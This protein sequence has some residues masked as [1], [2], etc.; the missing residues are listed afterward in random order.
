MNHMYKDE[1]RLYNIA[2]KKL[3]Q[4]IYYDPKPFAKICLAK[5]EEQT[6]NNPQNQEL[7]NIKRIFSK[8]EHN[9]TL[10]SDQLGVIENWLNQID[11]YALP[12]SISPFKSK[13]DMEQHKKIEKTEVSNSFPSEKYY[14]YGLNYYSKIP[15]PLLLLDVLWIMKVGV[16]LEEEISDNCYGARIHHILRDFKEK[17][18]SGHLMKRYADQYSA[19]R[20]QALTCA[21]EAVEKNE[22]VDILTLDF[23]QFY[24]HIEGDFAEIKEYLKL[25]NSLWMSDEEYGTALE[26]T[27]IIEKIH[28]KYYDI[29]KPYTD[30]THK[31]IKEKGIS[32]LLPIELYSS[33]ILANWH[34]KEFDRK[35]LESLHPR[36]Y[37]RYADDCIVVLAK[38]WYNSNEASSV[39]DNSLKHEIFRKCF[40]DTGIFVLASEEKGYQL[41]LDGHQIKENEDEKLEY[42]LYDER[43]E[44]PRITVQN[45]KVMLYHIDPKNSTA[46]LRLFQKKIQDNASVFQYLP[47]ESITDSQDTG[48]HQLVFDDGSTYKLRNLKKLMVDNSNFS[49]VLSKQLAHISLCKKP[50]PNICEFTKN[51]FRD[52]RVNGYLAY[53]KTWEK[54]FCLLLFSNT[55]EQVKE[56]CS[57][58]NEIRNQISCLT[59]SKDLCSDLSK[60]EKHLIEILAE[61]ILQ[62][63]DE[64]LLL[65]IATPL[66]LF[67][68][69]ERGNLCHRFSLAYEKNSRKNLAHKKISDNLKDLLL[70]YSEKLRSANLFPHYY[71]IYP[72]LNYLK[73][74]DGDLLEVDVFN[75][76]LLEKPELDDSK[77][78]LSPRFIHLYEFQ[79]Y[80]ALQC[81]K[82]TYSLKIPSPN[83][84]D[85]RQDPETLCY[86]ELANTWF[87][88]ITFKGWKEGIASDVIVESL[89]LPG[90]ETEQSVSP[91]KITIRNDPLGTKENGKIRIGLA[92]LRVQ[93]SWIERCYE[94]LRLPPDVSLSRWLEISK[95]LNAA[96]HDKCDLVVFPECSIPHYWIAKLALWSKQHQIGIVCGVEYL[97]N[98]SAADNL[99]PEQ[100]GRKCIAFNV[101]AAFLPYRV[102]NLYNSCCVSLRVKN[103]YAPDE[104]YQLQKYGYDLP[105]LDTYVYNLYHWNDTQFT[106]YNC[107]ELADIQHRGIFRSE[108]DCMIACSLNKDI[109]YFMDILDSV[110]RD[111]HCYVIYSNTAEFGCSRVI[112]PTKYER[113]NVMQVGGGVSSTLL[114]GELDISALAKFQSKGYDKSDDTFKPLPPGFYSSKVIK[115]HKI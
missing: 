22:V 95:I 51:M 99:S 52:L 21:T 92:N 8:F 57:L 104:I 53:T 45:D 79:L 87:K 2:Y 19:W 36:Y 23:V 37:G 97:F 88:T 24:Y 103:H 74:Y 29:I 114:T 58:H 15:I 3:K 64:Y 62:T 101:T 18:A 47:E 94:P 43:F 86:L 9:E 108:L 59:P 10:S 112:Q 110:A 35:I 27:D 4:T 16:H 75:T 38:P 1:S 7:T 65:S 13:E 55:E 98:C 5:Y 50:I 67:S 11:F 84:R 96:V 68:K 26:L 56:A 90:F 20:N 85:E 60:S 32:R 80:F 82:T 34:L 100:G 72:L 54:V 89:Q 69:E 40:V 81:L 107:Y 91:T 109:H 115:R 33:G 66:A 12:K 42:K 83:V 25:L 14:W 28:V 111:V 102:K 39:P 6:L 106:I 76:N 113:K 17:D 105:E 70:L 48:L 78:S 30:V 41:D 71:V 77:L 63:L 44:K 31:S 61:R 93:E 49:V 46:I 73:D